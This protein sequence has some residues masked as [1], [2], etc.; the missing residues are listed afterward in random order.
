MPVEQAG[1]QPARLLLIVTVV[2]R[3]IG[4]ERGRD[5]VQVRGDLAGGVGGS[6]VAVLRSWIDAVAAAVGPP[7]LQPVAQRLR[8]AA[9]VGVVGR[10]VVEQRLLAARQPP[11]E[12]DD[13][14]ERVTDAL[15]CADVAP[16]ERL[17]LLDRVRLLADAHALADHGV[18]VDEPLSAQ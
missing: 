6:P 18:Q 1:Q 11:L 10:D 8:G 17:E 4:D 7:L 16:V 2:G 5:P 15:V 9:V 13:A 12:R 14:A 3:H